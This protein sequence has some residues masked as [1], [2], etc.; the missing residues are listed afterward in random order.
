MDLGPLLLLALA[1]GL[2]S[3]RASVSIGLLETPPARKVQIAIA[4]GLCDA[5]APLAGLIAGDGFLRA[6]GPW[7]GSLGALA[8]AAYG[9]YLLWTGTARR[10][11]TTQGPGSWILFGLPLAL[12]LDNLVAGFGLGAM[13]MPALFSAAVLGVVSGLMSLAGLGLAHWGMRLGLGRN[14]WLSGI[15]AEAVGGAAMI[16]VAV[17]FVLE[18][19]G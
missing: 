10:G 19:N 15:S 8:M 16:L 1:L 2:D 7:A 11:G 3:L 9:A 4:F 17:S 13:R 12:S 5:V 18:G 14:R 6:V